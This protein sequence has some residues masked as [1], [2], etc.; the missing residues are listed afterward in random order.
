MTNIVYKFKHLSVS[1]T[2]SNIKNISQK[3]IKNKVFKIM[4]L[5]WNLFLLQNTYNQQTARTIS[6]QNLCLLS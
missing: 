4:F 1:I 6:F 5:S 3:T 2:F